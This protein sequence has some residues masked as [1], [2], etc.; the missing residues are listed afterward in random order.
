MLHV[1]CLKKLTD[2]SVSEKHSSLL[3][4]T[5]NYVIRNFITTGYA[6]NVLILVMS[7]PLITINTQ[8]NDTHVNVNGTR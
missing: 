6:F 5:V 1:G 8:Q 4:N 2:V 7:T 3:F